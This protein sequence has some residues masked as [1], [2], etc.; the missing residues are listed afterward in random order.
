MFRLKNNCVNLK[1]YNII[2]NLAEMESHLPNSE[3][4]VEYFINLIA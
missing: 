2:I 1:Y 4:K 3:S